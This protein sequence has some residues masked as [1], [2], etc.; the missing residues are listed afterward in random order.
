MERNRIPAA[1]G[2]QFPSW[3]LPEVSDGVIVTAESRRPREEEGAAE[4]AEPAPTVTAGEL[5]AITQQA[6]EEGHEAGYRDGHAEGRA[7]GHSEG[8]AAGRAEAQAELDAQ[9]AALRDIM[10][11]L[12]APISQ[13]HEAIEAALL[14]LSLDI[15]RAVLDREPALPPD[16]LLPV[17]REAVRQLPVGERNITVML[18]PEQAQQ[19]QA[20]ADWPAS[21]RIEGDP[22]LALNG[23]RVETEHALVDYTQSL[24]F[25]QVAARLLAAEGETV[26]PALL[27]D[28][29]TDDD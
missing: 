27:L 29:E 12:Q 6:W 10:A 26:E 23:C 17:V 13:Q 5:E 15:A 16:Q 24:R 25:R 19:V 3:E 8:L 7:A 14:R 9:L 20:A 1:A 22:S 18:N 2:A 4:A 11:A 28:A 21:W